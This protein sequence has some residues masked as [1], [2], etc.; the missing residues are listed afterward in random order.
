MTMDLIETA[1][2]YFGDTIANDIKG[3]LNNYSNKK[4]QMVDVLIFSEIS[5]RFREMTRMHVKGYSN[6]KMMHPLYK[7][8]TRKTF[9]TVEGAV[10][11]RHY[12]ESRTFYQ[13]IQ[14][15]YADINRAY[16]IQEG[17]PLFEES[18]AAA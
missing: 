17:L 5:H 3:A 14:K 8:A 10:R 6:W 11:Q 7:P 4:L 12:S 1:R 13:S 2:D 18:V 15:I 16:H 9:S